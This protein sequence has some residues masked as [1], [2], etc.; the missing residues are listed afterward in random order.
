MIN[1]I[2]I[3]MFGILLFFPGVLAINVDKPVNKGNGNAISVY[4]YERDPLTGDANPEGAWAKL[5]YKENQGSYLLIGHKLFEN[6]SYAL[7]KCQLE[8]C[9]VVYILKRGYSRTN[10][11]LHVGGL[12]DHGW[13]GYFRL[14]PAGDVIG[15]EMDFSPDVINPLANRTRW[16]YGEYF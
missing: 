1:K 12:W 10:G 7:V 8:D 5:A 13:I 15:D 11:G 9:S 6:Q 16:L 14:I 2:L 3:L 4:L